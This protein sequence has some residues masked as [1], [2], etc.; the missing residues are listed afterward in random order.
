MD[1]EVESIIGTALRGE[2]TEDQAKRLARFG[3]EVTS[4]A[5]LAVATKKIPVAKI[6]FSEATHPREKLNEETAEDYGRAMKEG[7]KLPPI[8]VFHD[9]KSYYLA[10][11]WHR[12]VG[13][14]KFWLKDIDADV[15]QGSQREATLF[16]VGANHKHGLRRTNADKRKAVKIVLDD[17]EWREWSVARIA[18]LCNVSW[19]LVDKV[20]KEKGY[21]QK[22]EDS[23]G[24]IVE[25]NDT[26]YRQKVARKPSK[27]KAITP[28]SMVLDVL[29]DVVETKRSFRQDSH[30]EL[31]EE[32]DDVVDRLQR[33]VGKATGAKNR[34][35]KGLRVPLN[36][37]DK[38]RIGGILGT[39]EF[40]KK[41]MCNYAVNVGFM[42]GHQCTYC[43]S[44][45]SLRCH[46]A[47]GDVQQTAFRKGYAILDSNTPERIRRDPPSLTEADV[48]QLCTTDDAW[49]PEAQRL[50]IGRKCLE[51]LLN[52]T[53]A[54]V[55]I[56]TKNAAVAE[57][58]DVLKP[59]AKRVIVGLSTGIPASREDVA[60]AVEPNASSV[61]DRLA[62]LKRAQELE[63]RTYGML[64]PVLPGVADD[65]EHLV[66]M[67]NAVLERGAED[68]WLEP[69]NSRGPSRTLTSAALRDAGLDTEAEA[70]D[71]LKPAAN[72]SVYATTLIK[73]AIG[74]AK[75]LGVLDK[76]HILLY[77]K[78]LSPEHEAELR[79]CKR[80]II[81]LE[82]EASL[83]EDE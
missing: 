80:G 15:R 20:W 33:I 10:D 53:P 16:A 54:Q 6:E 31:A 21:P 67:F 42:C 61:K 79:R 8:I 82:K 22:S 44:G 34:M 36:V 70:M 24:R 73:T 38:P 65:K 30:P 14:K 78:R 9:G 41:G 27:Q 17:E 43:S 25:R 58:F 69:V 13:A 57:D 39:E 28:V 56:L 76:L 74:V 83:E 49:S 19:G 18:G 72:W 50:K 81:W 11:G 5:L 23:E 59:H 32:F 68:I 46:E 26:K 71:T 2:L 66:E 52:E 77:P 37:Y 62:A 64:C 1:V 48:V 40:K 12:L 29:D 63:I 55:R 45:A 51:F 4:L 7:E 75:R 60:A 35:T 47:F 3:P